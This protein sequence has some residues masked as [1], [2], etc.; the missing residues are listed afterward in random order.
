MGWFLDLFDVLL[1]VDLY[2]AR[3]IEYFGA[4]SYVALGGFVF[5]ETGVV[6]APF[7]PGDSFMFAAGALAARG[8][9]SVR[10][11]FPV[12]VVAAILGDTASYLIGRWCRRWLAEERSIRWIKPEHFAKTEVFYEKHGPKMVIIARFVPVLCSLAPFVAGA[13][14]MRYQTFLGV[15]A[16]GGFLWV[17][18]FLWAGYFF[19]GIPLVRERFSVFVAG[20]ALLSVLPLLI[21]LFGRFRARRRE[22][23]RAALPPAQKPLL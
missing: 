1:H 8:L 7:L 22:R 19:G 14:N 6:I 23:R 21:D 20:V 9:L 17:T 2:L 12:F 10:V 5:I 15:N 13:S 11:L 4:W 16:L 18:V 3:L